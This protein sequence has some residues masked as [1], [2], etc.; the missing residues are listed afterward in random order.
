MINEMHSGEFVELE[1]EKIKEE[2]D[3]MNKNMRNLENTLLEMRVESAEQLLQLAVLNDPVVDAKRFNL[4]DL[5]EEFEIKSVKVESQEAEA[6]LAAFKQ[7][8][9][10]QINILGDVNLDFEFLAKGKQVQKKK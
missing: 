6:A 8:E 1:E 9:R 4:L 7:E 5:I 10:R 3:R 2:F